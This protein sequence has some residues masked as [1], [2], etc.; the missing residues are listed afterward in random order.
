[1]NLHRKPIKVS[2]ACQ[3]ISPFIPEG[4]KEYVSIYESH[5]RFLAEDIIATNH[6]PPFDKAP[7]DGFAIRSID[8]VGANQ[9]NRYIFKVVDHIGAGYVSEKEV[10]EKEAVRI[11]TGAPMPKG[12][13]CVMMLELIKEIK[14]NGEDFI[15]I[16]RELKS[17]DN[18][19]FCGED[20]KEG[21]VVVKK[22]TQINPGIQAVLATF[23]Y[24]QVPVA[25]KP[26]VGLFTTGTELIDVSMPLE[27]GKIRNSNSFMVMAQ[28]ERAGAQVKYYGT[29]PDELDLCYEKI[30]NAFTE[31]DLLI[32]TGGVSVGDFDLLP[33]IYEKMGAQVLFNKVAM[34]PGSVTTVAQ[35]DGKL[36]FGLSG[37]PSASY[38]GFELFAR[39]CIRKM[40]FT[41]NIYLKKVVGKLQEDFTKPNPFDRF[42]RSYATFEQGTVTVAP[43]GL[44]KS[45]VVMSL[46]DTNALTI[47]PGGSRGFMSG[48]EVTVLL[49]NDQEGSDSIW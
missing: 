32:T 24:A 37:N 43:S 39:P 4:T 7:Y 44:D 35:K 13:D 47:L 49:L 40:L 31:V 8:T 3:L 36:L 11:M 14:E 29:L 33:V 30:T 23:G 16:K 2:E 28:I 17:G 22:G 19:S 18:V 25:K 15:E 27:P 26:V 21:E 46:I 42:V 6:V 5:G 9:S 34:R 45:N 38:V 48:D 20:A 12:A 41:P 1:M 10:Q